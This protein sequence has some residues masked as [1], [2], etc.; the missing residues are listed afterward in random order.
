[1]PEKASLFRNPIH[2]GLIYR[3]GKWTTYDGS[4]GTMITLVNLICL[5][6]FGLA[7]A[8][9]FGMLSYFPDLLDFEIIGAHFIFAGCWLLSLILNGFGYYQAS[10]LSLFI[11]FHI[12]GL[13]WGLRFGP[14]GLPGFYYAIGI[15]QMAM[16]SNKPRIFYS[17]LILSF[18][19]YICIDVAD[20]EIHHLPDELRRWLKICFGIINFS[21]MAIFS[22]IFLFRQSLNALSLDQQKKSNM[23][24]LAIMS[25]EIR[26]P[27]A[28][29]I[30]LT[31]LLKQ[32][33]LA[34]RQEQFLQIIHIAEE[35][36]LQIVNN[37]LD[38][39]KMEESKL[40]LET[41]EFDLID[42]VQVNYF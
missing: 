40:I 12:T 37:V 31:D 13:F 24:F 27:L 29:I 34:M 2:W 41:L 14:I 32:T 15:L 18:S 5:G 17:L 9:F 26:T 22:G 3:G 35:N 4:V 25:H 30:G 33:E 28:S 11:T 20:A 6:M 7:V 36:L 39:A 21:G 42:C 19:C 10:V 23:K 1:M 8:S 16:F 38:F